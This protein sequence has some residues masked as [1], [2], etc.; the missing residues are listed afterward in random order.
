MDSDDPLVRRS[1]REVKTPT[2][3]KDFHSALVSKPVVNHISPH[4]LSRVLTYE[5]L[6]HSYRS[7]ALAVRAVH[8]PVLSKTDQK[9]RPDRSK[10]PKKIQTGPY[11]KS[12]KIGPDRFESFGPF[13]LDRS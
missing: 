5:H 4:D 7:F 11:Q 6:S 13:R 3:L 12:V 8:S 2:F 10:R 9:T 1:T